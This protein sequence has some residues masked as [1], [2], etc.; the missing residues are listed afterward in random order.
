MSRGQQEELIAGVW[1]ICALCAFG[2]GFE[3]WGWAFGAKAALDTVCAVYV[4]W[5]DG[6]R[7]RRVAA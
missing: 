7:E 5:V 3:A 1:A 6:V 2:F 4:S